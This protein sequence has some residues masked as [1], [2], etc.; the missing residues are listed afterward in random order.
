MLDKTSTAPASFAV[1]STNY[2][3]FVEAMFGP[4]QQDHHMCLYRITRT[5]AANRRAVEILNEQIAAAGSVT[6]WLRGK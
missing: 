2:D 1:T 6:D 4:A 3:Q 5:N